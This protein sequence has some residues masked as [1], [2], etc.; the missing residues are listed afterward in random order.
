MGE[1]VH[2]KPPEME[3]KFDWQARL[4]NLNWAMDWDS[5][6]KITVHMLIFIR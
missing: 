2:A 1:D 6:F 3:A 4:G 5:A